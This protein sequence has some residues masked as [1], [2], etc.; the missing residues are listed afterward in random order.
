M[1]WVLFDERQGS[2]NGYTHT[3]TYT[4]MYGPGNGYDLTGKSGAD[5]LF[6]DIKGLEL[7]SSKIRTLIITMD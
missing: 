6:I 1:R 3:H 7:S 4:H 2:L 5:E